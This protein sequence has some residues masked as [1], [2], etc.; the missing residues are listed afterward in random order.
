MF[1]SLAMIPDFQ[2]PIESV[3]YLIFI[4]Q[5]AL[6]PS[7]E[8]WGGL[9]GRLVMVLLLGLSRAFGNAGL[10]G[11]CIGGGIRVFSKAGQKL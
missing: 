10:A 2:L 11:G 7:S 4:Y 3:F 9:T 8:N 5:I 6:A 1:A